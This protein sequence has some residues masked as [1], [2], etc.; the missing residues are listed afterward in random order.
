MYENITSI[1]NLDF[2]VWNTPKE[3]FRMENFG[4]CIEFRGKIYNEFEWEKSYAKKELEYRPFRGP[5]Y[6]MIENNKR[7]DKE[8]LE[9]PINPNYKQEKQF[10]DLKKLIKEKPKKDVTI[11]NNNQKYT[12]FSLI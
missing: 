10:D 12:N 2:N 8:I 11:I 7:K 1:E 6:E 3:V 4:K 9:N 5:I